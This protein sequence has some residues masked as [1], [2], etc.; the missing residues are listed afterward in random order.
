MTC[1]DVDGSQ[2]R[3]SPGAAG[4]FGKHGRSFPAL[5]AERLHVG[6]DA[7]RR[8]A[9]P[10]DVERAPIPEQGAPE[11][12]RDAHFNPVFLDGIVVPLADIGRPE[13]NGGNRNAIGPS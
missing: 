2:G 6:G 13:K 9:S 4:P 7:L 11:A 10:L 8:D 12:I 1:A 5:F 3:S